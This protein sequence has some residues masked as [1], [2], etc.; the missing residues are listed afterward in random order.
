MESAQELA[1][2]DGLARVVFASLLVCGQ[3]GDAELAPPQDLPQG[4]EVID[5]LRD[6]AGM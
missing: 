2:G 3:A 6:P 1:L 4:V 5:I